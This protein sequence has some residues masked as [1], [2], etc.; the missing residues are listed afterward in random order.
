LW[1]GFQVSGEGIGSYSLTGR[2][3]WS[4]EGPVVEAEAGMEQGGKVSTGHGQYW[5]A[6]GLVPVWGNFKTD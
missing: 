3:A 6:S 2:A 1:L 5:M 4:K